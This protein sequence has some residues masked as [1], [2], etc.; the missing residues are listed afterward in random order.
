MLFFSFSGFLYSL[1]LA[2]S[3]FDDWTVYWTLNPLWVDTLPIDLYL[4]PFFNAFSRLFLFS[5]LFPS[6]VVLTDPYG[7]S[8]SLPLLIHIV[9]SRSYTLFVMSLVGII[10]FIRCLSVS[11]ILFQCPHHLLGRAWA[12]IGLA[13]IRV[14]TGIFFW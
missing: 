11:S 10:S 12:H 9:L 1:N 2:K 7:R 5:L 3:G 14:S 13:L 6:F 4:F 8:Y